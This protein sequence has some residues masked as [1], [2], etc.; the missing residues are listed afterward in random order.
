MHQ[1]KM[2]GGS[3]HH[4]DS[5]MDLPEEYQA[6][7]TEESHYSYAFDYGNSD[8]FFCASGTGRA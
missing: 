6:A 7:E 8:G 3:C 5:D 2:S 4:P 1:F